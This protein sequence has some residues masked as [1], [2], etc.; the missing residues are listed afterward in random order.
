MEDIK[1]M[2]LPTDIKPMEL[3]DRGDKKEDKH[4]KV[5]IVDAD[6]I[7]F[8]ACSVCQH[9]VQV[10][11]PDFMSDEEMAYARK[12]PYWDEAEMTYM[13]I[14]PQDALRHSK[15]KLELILDKIGGKLENTRLHFTGGKDSFRYSLLKNAFPND[16]EMHYKWKRTNKPRPVGLGE[17][18]GLMCEMEGTMSADIWYSFEADDIAV[19]EKMR[20]G[21]KAILVAVDKD[22]WKN[23]P[24][25]HFNYYESELYN[26]EMK[27]VEVDADEARLH[28]YLQAITG[29]KSDNIPGLKGIGPAKALKFIE[30]GMSESELWDGV[31]AAYTRHCKY[32]DPL[33][34]AILNMQLVNM[35][36]LDE[37]GVIQLWQP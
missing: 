32:G 22:V 26:I 20:Y 16:V 7:V 35:H 14:D 36:Q 27:W 3:D 1:P 33:D 15:D 6:T 12:Q 28:Q 23:T 19:E 31:V 30:L 5:I 13:S 11:G 17:V 37:D 25:L 2:E 18:K 21:D 24:G 10:M 8:A 34:M 9:E 29:D 4:D